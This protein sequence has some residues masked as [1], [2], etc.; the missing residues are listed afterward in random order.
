[1]VPKEKICKVKPRN[2]TSSATFIVDV[3]HL[4]CVDDIRKDDFGIWNYSRSHP[5]SYEVFV[6]TDGYLNTEKCSYDS[7]GDNVLYL[8][9]L[10]C[11]HP[12]NQDFKCISG[13]YLL[14]SST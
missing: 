7:S 10:H 14:C 12:S 3:C 13:N 1:M 6:Q 9:R 4:K 8:R 5:Q 11:T 2:I